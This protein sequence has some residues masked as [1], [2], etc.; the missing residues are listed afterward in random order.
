MITT[1]NIQT[2][3]CVIGGGLSGMCAAIAAARRGVPTV[4]VQDRPVLGGNASSEIRMH[5]CGSRKLLESGLVE[6]LRLANLARNPHHNYS[7]WDSIL[8]EKVRFQE[9]LT[10]LL[11]AS[12]LD[13]EASGPAD[14]RHI[15]SVKVW[16]LTTYTMFT[17]Q[18]D[19]FV[20][21][22]GDSILIEPSGAEFR[23]GHEARAEF[24]ET[25][26]PVEAD[27]KV[28]GMSTLLE[29]REHTSPRKFIAPPW[30]NRYPDDASLFHREH[31]LGHYQNC[32]GIEFGG[33]CKQPVLNTESVR[34]ELLAAAFG[35][36][37]HVK[38]TPGHHAE[39]WDLEW[40][41]FLP[42][43]RES[44]RYVGDHVLT[45]ADV[46]AEGKFPDVVAFGGWPLDDHNPGGFHYPGEP[47][48]FHPAPGVFGIPYRC[49]YSR[50]VANLWMAG[51]NVSVSHVALS[52]TR[53][54]ATCAL[55]G[56]AVGCAAAIAV[57]DS[58]SPRAVGQQRIRELQQTLLDNDCFLPGVDRDIDPFCLQA[59]LVASH[60]DAEALR[61]GAMRGH[62]WTAADGD[63]VEY[64]LQE[65]A[66]VQEV[67]LVF[68]SDLEGRHQ[69]HE[70]NMRSNYPLDEPEGK[71][72]DTLVRAYRLIGETDGH[73]E[74][75]LAEDRNNCRR[76]VKIPVQAP[77]RRIRLE[78]QSAGRVCSFDFH[79]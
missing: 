64:V 63:F 62:A 18:A 41:G 2:R 32:W 25:I 44:R 19:Y 50:N 57:R 68:D 17:I 45:E 77:L 21:A 79:G 40:V 59:R 54:M 65:P 73:R 35:V 76:L 75:V 72:P 53:V 10:L 24:N 16:Q 74:T 27:R 34:D 55:F 20:D 1:Q 33:D 4:L 30:A 3:L 23:D 43:K 61:S 58:L 29:F 69:R 39:N 49:L 46:R 12:C 6:E 31:D 9:N 78:L 8:Y 5:I 66:P 60:G 37:D 22:S 11:N 71:L 70:L 28:M 36:A 48:I 38:N 42:G 14:A 52:S 56:E 67:R 13:A 51:R 47:N 15:H 26:A 7:V